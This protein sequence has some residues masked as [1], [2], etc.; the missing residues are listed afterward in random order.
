MNIFQNILKSG[1]L[2]IQ[3]MDFDSIE[4]LPCH[5]YI[6]DKEGKFVA[7]NNIL[8]RN[9]G[10]TAANDL[11]GLND[12]DVLRFEQAQL[13]KLNDDKVLHSDKPLI[14]REEAVLRNGFRMQVTSIKSLLRSHTKKIIGIIGLS[15]LHH[16]VVEVTNGCCFL[17]ARHLDCLYYLTKGYTAKEI[18]QVLNLSHRTVEHHF[19]FIRL[20]LKCTRRSA[21]IAKA[22]LIPEIKA[23]LLRDLSNETSTL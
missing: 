13:I 7:C 19:E 6:K 16:G 3:N 15:V 9:A 8:V 4:E 11:I 2:D 14:L 10:F 20:K 12:F 18:S 23:R 17:N 21:L 22:M 1:N 5:T